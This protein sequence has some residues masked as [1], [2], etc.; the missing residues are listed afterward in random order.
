[1]KRLSTRQKRRLNIRMALKIA[2]APFRE[3]FEGRK[4]LYLA[5][6]KAKSRMGPEHYHR[7]LRA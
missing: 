7:F 6:A 2:S 4:G 1:M 5:Y 3:H